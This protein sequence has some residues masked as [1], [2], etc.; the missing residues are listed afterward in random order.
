VTALLSD[1]TRTV[2]TET[3]ATD[4]SNISAVRATSSALYVLSL[5]G[6]V[7]VITVTRL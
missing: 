3:V 4:L 7:R 6:D 1:G 2:A 5:E